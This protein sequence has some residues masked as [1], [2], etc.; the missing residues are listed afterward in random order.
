[1]GSNWHESVTIHHG[2]EIL[3]CPVVQP[4]VGWRI[5]RLD[6]ADVL[7]C[8]VVHFDELTAAI[9]QNAADTDAPASN[10]GGTPM[11]KTPQTEEKV[12]RRESRSDG[13]AH[14]HPPSR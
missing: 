13:P 3:A 7:A 4:G 1:M 11:K 2:G 12:R 6:A 8:V 9:Y 10:P 14:L 5:P